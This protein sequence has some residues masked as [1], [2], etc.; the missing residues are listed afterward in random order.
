MAGR[1]LCRSGLRRRQRD[2]TA[3]IPSPCPTPYFRCEG[4][5]KPVAANEPD[6]PGEAS[7]FEDRRVC[8]RRVARSKVPNTAGTQRRDGRWLRASQARLP[9]GRP[10]PVADRRRDRGFRHGRR[11]DHVDATSDRGRAA[12]LR[13]RPARRALHHGRAGGRDVIREAEHGRSH[14]RG[15]DSPSLRHDAVHRLRGDVLRR[16]VL[17]LFRRRAVPRRR[18]CICARTSSSAASGRPRAS[19][20]SIPGTCRCSTR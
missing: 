15:P 20:P 9:P 5:A 14:P 19:R 12:R 8:Y 7:S 16:L 6:R 10:E 2:T 13:H 1:L 17:G 18:Q 11:R 4:R 3:S